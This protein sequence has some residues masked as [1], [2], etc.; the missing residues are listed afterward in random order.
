MVKAAGNIAPFEEKGLADRISHFQDMDM[1]NS[2][3]TDDN[4]FL[5][6]AIYEG[7]MDIPAAEKKDVDNIKANVEKAKQLID[8]GRKIEAPVYTTRA[9]EIGRSIWD[10]HK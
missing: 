3:F 6:C 5:A 9:Y 7:V 2:D 4:F 8:T 10:K 1:V